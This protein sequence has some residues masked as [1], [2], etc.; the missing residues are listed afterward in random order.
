MTDK[1]ATWEK[2]WDAALN[3]EKYGSKEW[4]ALL[5]KRYEELKRLMR[6][7][8]AF[9]LDAFAFEYA[10]HDA[11]WSEDDDECL[12]ALGLTSREVARDDRLSRLFQQGKD[13][14]LGIEGTPVNEETEYFIRCRREDPT[15]DFRAAVKEYLLDHED[16]MEEVVKQ[17]WRD[18]SD[19]D[20]EPMDYDWFVDMLKEMDVMEVFELGM[21]SPHVNT[22]AEW[23]FYDGVHVESLDDSER[24]EIMRKAVIDKFDGA[25]ISK[26]IAKGDIEIPEEMA[27]ILRMFLDSQDEKRLSVSRNIKPRTKATA[28]NPAARPKT[29]PRRTATVKK[30]AAK[31]GPAGS[32]AKARPKTAVRAKPAAKPAT[33]AR[34]VPAARKTAKP[35]LRAKAPASG[36]AATVRRRA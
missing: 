11:N 24:L 12:S 34:A 25:E 4:N 31:K 3:K 30:T 23:F 13:R 9:A 8:D 35:A 28:K 29:A 2:R 19:P 22:G 6:T 14:A 1:Y 33:K 17:Y 32:K 27:V 26:A 18:I 36:K 21:G 5:D 10:N 20:D 16:V 7:D 15:F